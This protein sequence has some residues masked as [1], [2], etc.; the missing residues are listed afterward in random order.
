VKDVKDALCIKYVEYIIYMILFDIVYIILFS[1]YI[2]SST[3]SLIHG[4]FSKSHR[5]YI[6]A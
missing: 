5:E 4:A 3:T 6:G 1:L 2:M